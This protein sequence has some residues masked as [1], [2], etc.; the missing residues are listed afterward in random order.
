[1]KPD[2]ATK[3]ENIGL[4]IFK[5]QIRKNSGQKSRHTF[6][7]NCRNVGVRSVNVTSDN[8]YLIFSF[9]S[10]DGF[11]R[12]LD[13]D[14][15]EILP[16][17]YPGFMDSVRGTAVTKD[18]K[19]FW[20]SSW[21][22]SVRRIE[23]ETA[24]I[25]KVFNVYGRC[26]HIFLDDNY[27]F[28]VSYDSEVFPDLD[29][30]NGGRCWHIVSGK[31]LYFYKHTKPRSFNDLQAIDIAYDQ[32]FVYTGSD[33]GL[34]F[35]WKLSGRRPILQYFSM[36]GAVRKIAITSTLFIAASTDGFIRCHYKSSGEIY[37]YLFH[38]NSE[39]LDVRV[40]EDEKRLYSSSLDGSIKCFNLATGEELYHHKIHNN[41]IWSIKLMNG[42]KTLISGSCD[43]TIA[44]ISTDSGQVLVRFHFFPRENK[45]FFSIPPDRAFSNGF[46]YCPD[47]SFVQVEFE[48]KEKGIWE[49][50]DSKDIRRVTY[51][52]KL[53]LKNLVITRIKNNMSYNSLTD[54]YIKN[55]K[56]LSKP[57]NHKPLLALKAPS[58][59]NISEKEF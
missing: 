15:L 22:G 37:Q 6:K 31:S 24:K 3:R 26:P 36:Q 59:G 51:L 47:T 1:M 16:L 7:P 28:T 46:F 12:V 19:G 20:A 4:D 27:L 55:Q 41:W 54:N 23:I 5:G 49:I 9:I 13:L 18:N 38:S 8:K 11:L 42:D 17:N 48:N 52:E 14:K 56:L 33:D 50:L 30:V 39:V 40:S 29:Y 35:K 43:G 45:Y 44:F 25:T 34:A 2:I 57:I 53:N 10:Q 21:D 58:K 32:E